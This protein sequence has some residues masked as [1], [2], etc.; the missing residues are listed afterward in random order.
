M[1]LFALASR[2]QGPCLL[3]YEDHKVIIYLAEK[4]GFGFR[5]VTM[6]NTHLAKKNELLIAKNFDWLER[7]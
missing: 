1:K 3:T 7:E 6:Q 5:K 4:N 2:H